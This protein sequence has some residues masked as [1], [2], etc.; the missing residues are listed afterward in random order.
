VRDNR[1]ASKELMKKLEEERPLRMPRRVC[2]YNIE[3][4]LKLKEWWGV[5]IE[6]FWHDRNS[7]R[8]LVNKVMNIRLS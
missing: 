3:M 2:E 5:L 6:F 8:A 1:N 7:R 4:E